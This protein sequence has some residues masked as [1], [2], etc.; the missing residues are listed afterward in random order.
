MVHGC[1]SPE[2]IPDG[3][4]SGQGR[5]LT[6]S[7]SAHPSPLL[8]PVSGL[9]YLSVIVFLSPL[10]AAPEFKVCPIGSPV[11]RGQ[12]GLQVRTVD[13]GASGIARVLIVSQSENNYGR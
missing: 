11:G 5:L 13:L 1:L 6:C 8:G 12:L 7:P 10:E 9:V 4:G 3:P 2:A